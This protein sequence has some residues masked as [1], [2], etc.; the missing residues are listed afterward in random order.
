ML[1]SPSTFGE[2]LQLARKMSGLSYQGLA[3]KLN[4]LV[5]K[6]ALHKYEQGRMMP[7]SEKLIALANALDVTVNFF[8]RHDPV[9]VELENVEFRKQVKLPAKERDS[10]LSRIAD[11]MGRYLE[12]E[13]LMAAGK[14]FQ[15]PLAKEEEVTDPEQAEDMA[16]LVR[17]RW[18]L[19]VDGIPSVYETMEQQAIMV[20]ECHASSTFDGLNAR[21]DDHMVIVVNDEKEV[22][23][24][25]FTAA[26]ELGHAL[27]NI[28]EDL[29][30]KTKEQICHR[31]AG[32]FLWP[33]E[34]F[35]DRV[36]PRRARFMLDELV[37]WKQRWGLSFK[38]IIRRSYDL[39][40]INEATYKRSL[41][42][43][44]V[45]G[46]SKGEPEDYKMPERT[47]RFEQL[48]LS[49]LAQDILSLNQAA[50]L[51]NMKMGDFRKK[52]SEVV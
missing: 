8:F 10:I 41:I 32:A 25:R 37:E 46:Y 11:E 6:Q 21:V 24:K 39:G 45:A 44:N 22:V 27:L 19:G 49:G 15:N 47:V 52:Y 30:H 18:K 4:G 36:G 50:D 1:P 28:P 9:K 7:D 17:K 26:H 3:D 20:M 51:L 43:Y 14:K 12:A 40:I 34:Q 48:V 16:E 23:R 5:T 38:A 35:M 29:D 31:F 33:R 42:N 13:R 2:R